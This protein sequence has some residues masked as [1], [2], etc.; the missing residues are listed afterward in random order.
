MGSPITSLACLLIIIMSAHGGPDPTLDNHWK[1]WVL[2]HKKVYMN[3][4]SEEVVATMTGIRAPDIT[5]LNYTSRLDKLDSV[6]PDSIDWRTKDCVTEVKYQGECA[7]CWSF[8]ATGALECQMKLKTGKL[9]SLSEQELVDCSGSY[10]NYGCKGGWVENAIKYVTEHGL[11]L[12]SSYPYEGKEGTCR[13]A[14]TAATCRAFKMLSYG[15]EL[16]LQNAVGTV[17]PV[18]V[19][20]DS[21][22]QSF[23]LYK[24]GVYYDPKCNPRNLIHAVLAVGYDKE[25]GAAYWLVKNS[26]GL[27]WGEQGYIKMARNRFNHCG[28]AGH[29]VYPIV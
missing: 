18:S 1:L 14:P 15:N 11:A 9:Q 2:Q 5:E 25:N 19:L 6:F 13:S 3:A 8:S 27:G 23:Y 22:Q 24:N 20:I 4:T 7:S 28:I 10:G 26:W 29:C 12:E 17:G 21:S 16:L